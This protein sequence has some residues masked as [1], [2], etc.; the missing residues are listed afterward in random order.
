MKTVVFVAP[1][2]MDTT[3]RFIDAVSRVEGVR[4]AVVSQDPAEKLRPSLR[5][6]LAGHYRVDDA[7]GADGIAHGVTAIAKAL[8]PVHRLL[9]T[10][11][12]IQV[13]LAEVRERLGIDGMGVQTALRF[14]DKARMKDALRAAG[15]P[16][17]RHRRIGCEQDVHDFVAEVGL[18][19]VIKPLDGAAAAATFRVNDKEA[20]DRALAA[21]RP[22]PQRPA[23]AEELVMGEERSFETLSQGGAP[24]WHSGTRYAPQ[25]LRVIENPWIQWTV[26]LPGEPDA[27]DALAIREVGRAALRALGMGTG[28]TH[29]EWFLRSNGG[30]VVSE[31][32][33]RPP[34]AQIMTLNS[35]AHDVD[36]YH[37]WAHLVVHEELEPPLRRYA[38]GAAFF[39]GQGQGRVVRVHGLDE[40]QREV[41]SLVVEARLPEVGTVQPSSYEGAGYAIV[42]HPE[43]AVVEQALQRLVSTV[44][45]ELG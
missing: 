34:G 7:L 38:T 1:F 28:M 41:G 11:E 17:A 26:L 8:G 21:V 23:L 16:C 37:R 36:L 3:N 30:V 15:I 40:A 25:P 42:R 2:F 45:V 6:R 35:Y 14:R 9:G 44:R 18:P 43:T 20:L 32:A 27:G 4:L 13:Q 22:H 29:M 39:R 33:A 19:L 5:R 24:L 31:V 10:L 12:H